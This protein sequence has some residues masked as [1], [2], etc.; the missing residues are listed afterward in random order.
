MIK[1]VNSSEHLNKLVLK[2]YK[3]IADCDIDM[4]A[5]NVLIGAN[6]AGKSNFI[7]FFKLIAKILDGQLQYTVG[8]SG[9]PDAMLHFGRKTTEKMSGELYFGNN[10]YKFELEATQDNRLMFSHES[11]YW[12]MS[13]D[14]PF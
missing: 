10:G 7:G 8:K 12:N 5:L 4:G 1:P 3:S 9:G 11:L 2:G 13:G 14:R 6:G